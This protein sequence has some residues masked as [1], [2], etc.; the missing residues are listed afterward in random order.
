MINFP[1]SPQI[2]LRVFNHIESMCAVIL[3]K[4]ISFICSLFG[5]AVLACL[6]M[7]FKVLRG[8]ESV[9]LHKRKKRRQ[10]EADINACDWEIEKGQVVNL[11]YS[12]IKGMRP[13]S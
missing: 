9:R 4:P 5:S 12:S 10:T 13:W 3:V 6:K 8:M 7:V 11:A 1:I 2:P